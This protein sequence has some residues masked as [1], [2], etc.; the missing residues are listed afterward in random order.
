MLGK[1]RGES[2]V[3]DSLQVSSLS[4][5]SPS[6][7]PRDSLSQGSQS[8]DTTGIGIIE[9]IKLKN[10]M[11]HSKLDFQFADRVNFIVGR[12]GSGKSAI[13]TA[14][15]VGLGGKAASACRGTSVKGLV[16]TGTRSAEVTVQLS[17]KGP[18]AYR[19][20]VYGGSIIV[21][22][23][24][25][26]D[27]SS[28]YKI[29]AANG[30][31]VS[32]KREELLSI[33]DHF[34]VQIDNPVM[35]LNQ[36]T[37]RNFLQS[38]SPG[39]K[40][41]FFM[42]ATQLE[43]LK[44]DYHRIEEEC[45]ETEIEV[46]RKE[47]LLPE[48]EREVRRCEKLWRRLQS[49]DNQRQKLEH[50][51]KELLWAK[52]AQEEQV[53]QEKDNVCRKEAHNLEKLKEK[54]EKME[55][56]VTSQV[57]AQQA[58]QQE[59][60]ETMKQIKDT[61]PESS[62]SRKQFLAAKEKLKEC[63]AG[64]QRIER[65]VHQKKK[66]TTIL[67]DRIEE[68]RSVD[69]N[70]ATQ[71]KERREKQL[72]E[73]EERMGELRS[74][75]NTVE[76]HLKQVKGSESAGAQRLHMIRSELGELKE[77]RAATLGSIRNLQA[78]KSN[79]LQRYGASMPRLLQAIENAMRARK[80]RKPPKG[81]LGSLLKLKDSQWDLATE[82]CLRGVL[83]A[84]L[85]DN[86]QDARTL[87]SVM[88]QV[89]GNERKP[90]IIVSSY[91]GKIY[92]YEREALRSNRYISVLEN[93]DIEDPDVVN[94]LIDQRSIEKIALIPT[95]HEARSS[96]M[97]IDTVP[98]NC[99]EAFTAQG[100]Q[101]YPAPSF[102]Y[103]SSAKNRAELLKVGVDDQIREKSAELEEI[104]KRSNELESM[105]RTLQQDLTQHRNESC[106]ITKQLERL[107]RE[108]ME[109]RSRADE[110]RRVEDPEPTNIATLEDALAELENEMQTLQSQRSDAQKTFSEL[111]AMCK[112]ASDE[113]RKKEEARKQLLASAETTK[114]KLI[115]ADS[116]LQKVKGMNASH[117]DQISMVE[118]RCA[119]AEQERKIYERN[120]EKLSREAVAVAPER[121]STRRTVTTITNEI[122]A[123]KEQLE[124]EASR[125]E[126][127]ETVE[128]R[129]A[130]A[131]ERYNDMKANVGQLREFVKRLQ[132][133]LKERH[134]KYCA[135]C[136]KTVLRLR[137][138]FS[139]TLLQ[140]NFTGRLEFNHEK[141]QLH[142][143][144]KPSE[145]NSQ[146]QQD[147]KALSG[148]ERSF[149]TV[150][151]VLAL[152][153]TMECPFR[154]MDEFD[155]FMDMG[156]RRVS[157]E[158]ILEMTRCKEQSQFVFLTPIELPAISAF[159]T[160]NIMM[161]PEPRRSN[162]VVREHAQMQAVEDAES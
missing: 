58:L 42:K 116:E 147:L 144:V 18:D 85:C 25:S 162:G 138:I 117:R 109:L 158:M 2:H 84:F 153:D 112:A 127:R 74:E 77:R 30:T 79:N 57:D 24:L 67:K 10:F 22:R 114:E 69:H 37:S 110:L 104:E 94:C 34:N 49:M 132:D 70:R 130:Q 102:R 7:K 145:Q 131:K 133:S 119:D 51:Q 118:R 11:C 26:H 75:L 48:V 80:F 100:D 62:A 150:C 107:R 135:L 111:R 148:G 95:N 121:I 122:E 103:Y 15:I 123:I 125:T 55:G 134:E 66:E 91:M 126:S 45:I 99:W 19:P 13:L 101:L 115:Q 39:D 29:K 78:S 43:K 120:V 27:G 14:L 146:L 108:D 65:E 141:Q 159:S 4:D 136:E 140:Q 56:R 68:L 16:E 157:L 1:R 28:S 105:L 93:L 36:E 20:G 53:L 124:E 40:Y 160:V 81:P 90:S 96:L 82:S 3:N 137:L 33:L 38:K 156:K 149:S 113:V 12:N 32:S 46:V 31:V 97:H 87:R 76:H 89:M 83:L 143:Q 52:V 128:S 21:Q 47:K 154:V 98:R 41:R 139:S 155:I 151:F 23:R 88:G 61:Q 9:S 60:N 106:T 64:I 71:E 129:Y 73:I 161:M 86:D 59:L 152:W 44:A 8:E 54:I 35:V 72:G 17:N 50:L 5:L 142:I 6:K 63:E 92:N